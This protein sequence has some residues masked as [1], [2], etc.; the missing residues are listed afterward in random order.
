MPIPAF[1]HLEG[2]MYRSL[3]PFVWASKSG[4]PHTSEPSDISGLILHKASGLA[5]HQENIHCALTRNQSTLQ[6]FTSTQLPVT[7]GSAFNCQ[8]PECACSWCILTMPENV[9]YCAKRS[10]LL[11]I[12]C[13]HGKIFAAQ[14][15]LDCGC[16]K[17]QGNV[18][19]QCLR[20][21]A[22]F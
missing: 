15:S 5:P 10:H 16:A 14:A 2:K 13:R 21:Q 17:H 22:V 12:V 3:P 4:S 1:V 20:L 11:A 6:L 8:S 18:D 7:E 19:L 9:Q